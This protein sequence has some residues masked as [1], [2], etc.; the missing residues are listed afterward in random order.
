M[1]QYGQ[2]GDKFDPAVH[3]ALFEM[4]HDELEPGTVGQV[5]STGFMLHDTVLRAAEVGTVRAA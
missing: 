1:E 3:S 4:M 2:I 5:V